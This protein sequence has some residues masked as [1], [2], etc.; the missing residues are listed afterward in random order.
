[1]RLKDK[2]LSFVVNFLL[3][4]A[5]AS[6][7]IGAVTTFISLYSDSFLLALVYA[8]VA[9]LPGFIAVLVLEHFITS[10]EKQFELEK[11]TKLLEQ[12][13]KKEQMPQ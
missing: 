4:I 8:A 10:K 5:W 12:L 13:L 1:M 7:F 2:S 3:G 9:S 11:Q 6:A